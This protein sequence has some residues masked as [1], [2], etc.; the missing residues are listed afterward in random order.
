MSGKNQKK[1]KKFQKPKNLK[2]AAITLTSNSLYLFNFF[3]WKIKI[4]NFKNSDF[5]KL[6]W[7]PVSP[8]LKIQ[9]LPLGMMILRQNIFP[10][11]CP[12]LENSTTRIAILFTY[13]GIQHKLLPTFDID[14]HICL[15]LDILWKFSN[16]WWWENNKIFFFIFLFRK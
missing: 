10:I 2:V 7:L 9:K 1:T 11:L 15:M 13:L 14:F 6:L 4:I 12:P 8:I 16:K 3:T 5:Y